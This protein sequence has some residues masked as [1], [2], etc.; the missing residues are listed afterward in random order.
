[1]FIFIFTVNNE[2]MRL[3]AS[4]FTLLLTVSAIA[5]QR[6]DTSDKHIL[7]LLAC[8]DRFENGFYIQDSI[9][10]WF[11]TPNPKYKDS[12]Q[13]PKEPLSFIRLVYTSERESTPPEF[14][15]EAVVVTVDELFDI[16][17]SIKRCRP[18]FR[19]T[20]NRQDSVCADNYSHHQK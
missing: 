15:Q 6:L 7:E 17:D 9:N 12:G 1:M 16:P 4:V 14:L 20:Y 8:A 19:Q 10:I 3:I 5:Q 2:H 18:L 13:N 11:V